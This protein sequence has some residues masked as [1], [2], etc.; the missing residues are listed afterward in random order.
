MQVLRQV[1]MNTWQP[2]QQSCRDEKGDHHRSTN[3]RQQRQR[4][5]GSRFFFVR[6]IGNAEVISQRCDDNEEGKRRC[7]YAEYA[8]FSRGIESR[9]YRART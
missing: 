3:N 5:R 7:E 4:Q 9:D 8:E 1:S 2:G 6:R